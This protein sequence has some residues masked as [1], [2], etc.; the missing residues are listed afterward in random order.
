M[1]IE[2][3]IPIDG[4]MGREQV[5]N[6]WGVRLVPT[7]PGKA[8]RQ[9]TIEHVRSIGEGHVI[10][11]HFWTPRQIDTRRCVGRNRREDSVR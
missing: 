11:W 1:H 8:L 2:G 5:Q 3:S 6:V 7:Q 10:M 4:P 9:R